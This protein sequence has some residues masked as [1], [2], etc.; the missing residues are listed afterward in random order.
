MADSLATRPGISEQAASMA[1]PRPTIAA[2][3]SGAGPDGPLLSAAVDQVGQ[4]DAFAAVQYADSLLG[5]DFMAGQGK[6]VDILFDDIDGTFPTACTASGV[7][8]HPVLLADRTDFWNRLNG[9]D[10]VIGVHNAHQRCVLP[11][12]VFPLDRR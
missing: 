5:M 11:D 9:A 10:F 12:G 1:T 4:P 8:Q 6:Q 3:F 2:I 7:E